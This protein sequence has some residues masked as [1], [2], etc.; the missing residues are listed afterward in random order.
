MANIKITQPMATEMMSELRTG[1]YGFEYNAGSV[2]KRLLVYSGSRPDSNTFTTT[3]PPAL[4]F[5]S[6]GNVGNQG[7]GTTQ[8]DN[9]LTFPDT[10]F[11]NASLTG[12]ASYFIYITG[13]I[14]AQNPIYQVHMG[15]IGL[16]GSGAD[17]I[18]GN[19]S[20]TAGNPYAFLGFNYTLPL[21]YTY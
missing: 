9:T 3:L 10:G 21:E 16:P 8:T 18:I 5:A 12:T 7:M 4:W 20:M 1:I 14:E 11:I 2:R 17:I 13:L 19:T 15:D 6:F